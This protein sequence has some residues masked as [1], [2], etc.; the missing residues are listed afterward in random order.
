MDD[1]TGLLDGPRARD[2]FVLR[3]VMSA[4][5][6]VRVLDEA[7]V[8]ILAMAAGEAWVVP[9]VGE[10]VRLRAGD[11]AIARGP[12]H[13]TV[14][15]DPASP[16]DVEVLPD[17]MCQTPTGQPM[18][19]AMSLGVRS[20]GNDPAGGHVMIVGTY[21]STGDVS[22]RLWRALPP[23]VTLT[24]HEWDCP[25]VPLLCDEVVKDEPGQ[26]A[27]L[28]RLVDLVLIA[29]LRSWFSRPDADT[30]AWYRAQGDPLVGRAL[31]LIQNNPAHPWT[32]AALAS[33]V[34]L[35]R[36]AFARRFHRLVG[37]PP[38]AFLTDTRLTL[39]ADLLAD[40]DATVTSVAR[41]VGYS[42]PF[43]LSNAF[44]RVRGVSPRQHRARLTGA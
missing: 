29:A 39:A 6:S 43:A 25:L 40:P 35:S 11:V 15:D 1:L 9:D 8:T 32:V 14:A 22:D 3:M 41:R 7:P 16:V 37:E 42:T 12:H 26:S 4:P 19:E 31:R 13:Y 20:W 38:M 30:P 10:P 21:E 36:A 23:L 34:G 2:A 18:A 5:W 28:D 24:Q 17:Q 33:E 27:V 44:K